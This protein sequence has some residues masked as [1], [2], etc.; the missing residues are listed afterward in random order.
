[1]PPISTNMCCYTA[2]CLAPR[3]LL[4]C[5]QD[6]KA[7]RSGREKQQLCMRN[8]PD[9]SFRASSGGVCISPN[10]AL[11]SPAGSIF[12]IIFFLHNPQGKSSFQCF[13]LYKLTCKTDVQECASTFLSS[14]MLFIYYDGQFSH[15]YSLRNPSECGAD[16]KQI[17]KGEGDCRLVSY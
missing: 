10:H 12:L 15:F 11:F 9:G 16:A 6:T 14:R 1:M 5:S 7:G 17:K 8:P 4:T 13:C 3:C 2:N